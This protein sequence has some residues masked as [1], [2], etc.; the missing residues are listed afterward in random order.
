M[1]TIEAIPHIH[2]ALEVV[3]AGLRKNPYAFGV[4][5]PLAQLRY[6]KTPFYLSGD[7]SVPP[8]TIYFTIIED[9]QIVRIFDV[10]KRPGFGELGF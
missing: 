10:M 7:F 9:D 4:V 1:Q 2:E 3:Y 5:P 6:A 8:L